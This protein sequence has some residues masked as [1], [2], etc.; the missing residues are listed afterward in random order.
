M[1]YS[2]AIG[3]LVCYAPFAYLVHHSGLSPMRA[4]PI[5]TLA[6]FLT[7]WTAVLITGSWRRMSLGSGAAAG[8]ATACVML[9]A[10]AVYAMPV[11]VVAASTV[12]K[13]SVLLVGRAIDAAK[14]RKIGW[15]T[16]AAAALA[17]V[18]ILV[19]APPGRVA[20]GAAVCLGLYVAGYV[21]KLLLADGTK[22][23]GQRGADLNFSL[24][25]AAATA[26]SAL[27][28]LVVG[29]AV[30]AALGCWD[31]LLAGWREWGRA[32]LWVAGILSQ[33]T[34]FFG[35][36]VLLAPGDQTTSV[37]LN[38]CLGV[39]A[40]ASATLMSRSLH[41]AEVAG[42]S[43]IVAALFL[44]PSPSPRKAEPVDRRAVLTAGAQG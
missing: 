16:A 44:L 10:T 21:A 15:R 17:L 32:D 18:A 9:S 33:G 30:G 1:R 14:R 31:E 8:A 40:G 38:R 5:T 36:M 37:T 25:D 7:M 27:I 6:C 29:T 3:Y 24:S 22:A 2:S 41:P 20:V 39:L 35:T 23:V 11:A 19:A 42:F 28:V 4:L 13:G 26:T 43:L 12:M 34:G